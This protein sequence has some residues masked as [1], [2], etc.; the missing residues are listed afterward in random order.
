[1]SEYAQEAAEVFAPARACYKETE[2]DYEQR[3]RARLAE[4]DYC[5][6]AEDLSLLAGGDAVHVRLPRR[7]GGVASGEGDLLV[8]ANDLMHC[9]GTR[10]RRAAADCGWRSQ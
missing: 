7:R 8:V 6:A 3:V 2:Q 5:V 4:Q 9:R 10:C 1:M